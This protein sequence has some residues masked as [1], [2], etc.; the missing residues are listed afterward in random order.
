MRCIASLYSSPFISN[1]PNC[2][3]L[4]IIIIRK[5]ALIF[6]ICVIIVLSLLIVKAKDHFQYS[7]FEKT[8]PL[9]LAR[10]S[11][12]SCS[13]FVREV[14]YH[15]PMFLLRYLNKTLSQNHST[16]MFPVLSSRCALI[17]A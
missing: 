10:N 1:P 5:F 13:A 8:C 15:Q 2:F 3:Y 9:F 4:C 12:I 7:T 6:L 14:P 17:L 16:R 11:Q